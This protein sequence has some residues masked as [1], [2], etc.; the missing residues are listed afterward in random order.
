MKVHIMRIMKKELQS[1]GAGEL[2]VLSSDITLSQAIG[3]E[4]AFKFL[5]P[6]TKTKLESEHSTFAPLLYDCLPALVSP[7]LICSV[8]FCPVLLCSALFCSV[9][10]C[11]VLFCSVLPCSVPFCSVLCLC[12]DEKQTH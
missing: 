1:P 4:L 10:F 6:S 3:D 11:S 2:F 7:Y 9:L 12:L 8:L 5:E